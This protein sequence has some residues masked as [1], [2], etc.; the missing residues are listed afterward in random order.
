MI[1]EHKN[2]GARYK[3]LSDAAQVKIADFWYDAVIYHKEDDPSKLFVRTKS[4][5]QESF[6]KPIKQLFENELKVGDAVVYG[7]HGTDRRGII[8]HRTKRTITIKLKFST[9]KL[10]FI[11]KVPAS[12]LG[13][14]RYEQNP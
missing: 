14:R 1:Y 12:D 4:R 9:L 8:T 3:V 11:S 10:T 13:L 2:S 5:F 6:R 7:N